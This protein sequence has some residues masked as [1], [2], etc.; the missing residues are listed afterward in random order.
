MS[1]LEEKQLQVYIFC[2]EAILPVY[3]PVFLIKPGSDLLKYTMH[4]GPH[5]SIFRQKYAT[6]SQ[7]GRLNMISG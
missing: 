5:C 3:G 7:T 1:Y 6:H 4:N 2:F